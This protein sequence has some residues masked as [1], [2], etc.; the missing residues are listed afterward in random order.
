MSKS[1]FQAGSGLYTCEICGKR[2]RD[3]GGEFPL[4]LGC[5][6][7]AGDENTHNDN[8]HKGLICDCEECGKPA[9]PK[10]FTCMNPYE[11]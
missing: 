1:Y 8:R 4:C 2:T 6:E 7:Y 3:T 9:P 5:F 11:M 10:G